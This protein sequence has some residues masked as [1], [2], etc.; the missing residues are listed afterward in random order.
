MSIKIQISNPIATKDALKISIEATYGDLSTYQ[1]ENLKAFILQL[2]NTFQL[3]TI[4]LT[5]DTLID[6][7]MCMRYLKQTHTYT[8]LRGDFKRL[9][10]ELEIDL[11]TASKKKL[12]LK[13]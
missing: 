1:M 12:Q 10:D 13:K 8:W 5:T 6:L 2:P 11:V 7:M 9:L 3:L 4:S